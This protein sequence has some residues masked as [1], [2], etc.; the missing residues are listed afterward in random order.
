MSSSEDIEREAQTFMEVVSVT[1]ALEETP[2]NTDALVVSVQSTEELEALSDQR[3]LLDGRRQLN[4]SQ[5]Q[6]DMLPAASPALLNLR[7]QVRLLREENRRLRC[8]LYAKQSE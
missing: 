1:E 5:T 7:R 4:L 2:Y 6:T 3:H 8:E